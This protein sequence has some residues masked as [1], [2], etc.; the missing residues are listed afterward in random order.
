MAYWDLSSRVFEIYK[1]YDWCEN[2]RP[3]NLLQI[4]I[5]DLPGLHG[6]VDHAGVLCERHAPARDPFALDIPAK[7]VLGRKVRGWA[8]IRCRWRKFV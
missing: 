5:V 4:A 1:P 8:A 2:S 7:R 6:A 3:W